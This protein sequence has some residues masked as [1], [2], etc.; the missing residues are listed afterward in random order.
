MGCRSLILV[1]IALWG[2]L[3]AGAPGV[4]PSWNGAPTVAGPAVPV[5]ASSPVALESSFVAT[6]TGAINVSARGKVYSRVDGLVLGADDRE[7]AIKFGFSMQDVAAPNQGQVTIALGPRAQ[8]QATIEYYP[9]NSTTEHVYQVSSGEVVLS[10]ATQER[11]EGSFTFTAVRVNEQG[12]RM[13]PVQSVDVNGSFQRY[14]P[15]GGQ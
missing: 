14:E 10:T 2:F 15:S 11:I 7:L 4:H 9:P 3:P 6:L 13:T 5:T 8:S 1:L 12:N